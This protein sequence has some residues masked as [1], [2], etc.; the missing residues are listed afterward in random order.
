M[1]FISDCFCVLAER[2]SVCVLCLSFT[3]DVRFPLR[4]QPFWFR[5]QTQLL[6]VNSFLVHLQAIWESFQAMNI[7]RWAVFPTPRT[8]EKQWLNQI[9]LPKEVRSLDGFGKW[10]IHSTED[11][12]FFLPLLFPR[13]SLQCFHSLR[14]TLHTCDDWN[15]TMKK[16]RWFI[17]ISPFVP[18][19]SSRKP[20]GK[21]KKKNRICLPKRKKELSGKR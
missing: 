14:P 8:S 16:S 20:T 2:I 11:Q 12:H 5:F 21:E 6:I 13:L 7:S 3:A 4:P 10:L 19:V 15:N 17:Q 9:P 1:S 18:F